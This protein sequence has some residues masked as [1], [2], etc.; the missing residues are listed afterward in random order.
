MSNK[1]RIIVIVVLAIVIGVVLALKENGPSVVADEQTGREEVA[2]SGGLP[3]LVDLGADKC[4]PCKQMAPILEGLKREYAGRLTVDFIDVWKDP[5]QAQKY[6]V[7]IIP[8]QI[9]FDA[10]GVERFRHEGG[11]SK[12]DILNKWKELGVDLGGVQ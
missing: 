3:R 1:L 7:R 9:F 10:A 5:E 6:G 8:T 4:I 11:M 2:Q 12:A